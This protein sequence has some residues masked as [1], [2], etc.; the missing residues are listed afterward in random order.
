MTATITG[1]SSMATRQILTELSSA[2]QTTTGQLTSIESVGGVDAAKR[3]RAGE[4]FDIV[5]LADEAM[6]QL[7]EDGLLKPGSC[8]GFDLGGT[9]RGRRRPAHCPRKL[10][11]SRCFRALSAPRPPMRPAH[12]T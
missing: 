4:P 9:R 5:V 11:P 7:E 1:I 10:S 6:K 12:A 2:F 8:A 3:I